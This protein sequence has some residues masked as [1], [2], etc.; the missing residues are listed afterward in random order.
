MRKLFTDALWLPICTILSGSRN[1]NGRRS[2]AFMT[3]KIAVFAPIPSAS[4]STATA[5][6]P[7]F[8]TSW[9]MANLKS[10]ITKR[11]HRIDPRRAARRQPARQQC[12]QEQKQ[13]AHD[14]CFRVGRT[15][16]EQQTRH[17][18]GE[19]E[20]ARQTKRH[21]DQRRSHTLFER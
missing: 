9:R 11:L 18:T 12:D 19:G 10:F 14:E 7:G 8:L 1:G 5:V 15:H 4:V 6:K 20:C 3:L 21:S 13:R 17:Q 16:A 2:T